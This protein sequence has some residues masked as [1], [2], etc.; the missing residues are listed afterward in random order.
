MQEIANIYIVIGQS[1]IVPAIGRVA[2]KIDRKKDVAHTLLIGTLAI[3]QHDQ[4]AWAV[5]I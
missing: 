2:R 4:H 5:T 1:S 3:H